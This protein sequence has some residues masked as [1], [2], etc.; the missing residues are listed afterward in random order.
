MNK[1]KEKDNVQI[2]VKEQRKEI[3][4]MA[5]CGIALFVLIAF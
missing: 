4:L 5:L 1:T 2:L 3:F